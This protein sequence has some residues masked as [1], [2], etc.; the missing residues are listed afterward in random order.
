MI[1][2]PTLKFILQTKCRILRILLHT[3]N[4]AIFR[5]YL[6]L[7]HTISVHLSTD[8]I[9]R[10][11]VWLGERGG[12]RRREEITWKRMTIE[13]TNVSNE[14]VGAVVNTI[15]VNKLAL[16]KPHTHTVPKLKHNRLHT[17][18]YL[19]HELPPQRVFRIPSKVL[20]EITKVS[21]RKVAG[22]RSPLPPQHFA[23]DWG[24]NYFCSFQITTIS[25]TTYLDHD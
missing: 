2:C 15:R 24:C 22:R 11:K 20:N 16:C 1:L 21:E 9:W 13:F 7:R 3:F 19:N 10:S 6:W 14:T 8:D 18:V 5:P 17:N 12:E 23:F 4:W 25:Y